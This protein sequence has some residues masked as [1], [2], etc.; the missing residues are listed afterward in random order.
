MFVDRDEAGS[1]VAVFASRQKQ[2]Q[3]ELAA[4]ARDLLAFLSP[5]LIAS[6]QAL[7]T[8][9]PERVSAGQ[10]IRALE[11]VGLLDKVDAAVARA[12][13]LTQRLWARAPFFPRND[14]MIVT[15]A[16]ALGKSATEVDNL[17]RLAASL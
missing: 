2:G 13:S 11:N 8:P 16:Q 10:L 1:I 5:T 17:F 3:E 4:N 9:V 12:D 14:P 6:L 15:I 7:S